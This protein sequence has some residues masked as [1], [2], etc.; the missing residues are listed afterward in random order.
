MINLNGMHHR[1]DSESERTEVLTE[2]LSPLP[3]FFA[4]KADQIIQ[5]DY[6]REKK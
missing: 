4:K 3:N 6:R 1:T 2:Y 5:Y